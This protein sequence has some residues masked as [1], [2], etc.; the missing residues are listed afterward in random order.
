METMPG[1]SCVGP[2]LYLRETI[3]EVD[4]GSSCTNSWKTMESDGTV[5]RRHGVERNIRPKY[6]N[7]NLIKGWIEV[8]HV[9]G[10]ISRL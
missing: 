7:L 6:I 1:L 10:S 4:G 8:S 5:W 2:H 9:S 3:P